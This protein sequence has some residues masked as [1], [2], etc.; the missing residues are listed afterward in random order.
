MA[1]GD[2]PAASDHRKSQTRAATSPTPATKPSTNQLVF[3]SSKSPQWR[4]STGKHSTTASTLAPSPTSFWEAGLSPAVCRNLARWIIRFKLVIQAWIPFFLMRKPI[5]STLTGES[6]RIKR[7]KST[8]IKRSNIWRLII[9]LRLLSH[10]I[11]K[12]L[13]WVRFICSQK[14][15]VKIRDSKI[16]KQLRNWLKWRKDLIHNNLLKD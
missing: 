5:C 7:S 16:H 10:L 9:R 2:T 3:P 8:R 1:T 6:N 11:M 12:I 14:W 4:H 13:S 15:Y